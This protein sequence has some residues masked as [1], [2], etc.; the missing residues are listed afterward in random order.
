MIAVGDVLMLH[1]A[2]T[3]ASDKDV[4]R[5]CMVVTQSATIVVVAPRSVSV[6]RSVPTPADASPAF[7]KPGSF[8]RWRRPVGRA[9]ADDAVFSREDADRL[10]AEYRASAVSGHISDSAI[11]RC[12][13]SIIRD[14]LAERLGVPLA[15]RT[16]K[17]AAGAPVQVDA[18]SPDGKVLAEFARQ[19]ELKGGQ[20]KKVAIDQLHVRPTDR[21]PTRLP[22]T[23]RDTQPTEPPSRQDRANGQP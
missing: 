16:I 21:F 4:V 17:L 22:A 15:A 9:A 12:A 6:T 3:G 11:Q 13:E 10:A 18:A 20:Q 19:G 1:D 23:R 8:S 7:N 2:D 5:P 14:R